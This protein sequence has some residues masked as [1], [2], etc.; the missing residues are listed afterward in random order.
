MRSLLALMAGSALVAAGVTLPLTRGTA[1]DTKRVT[2]HCSSGPNAAF[3]TPTTIRLS[4]GDSLEWRMAGNVASDSIQITLK[5]SD[6]AW[7]FEGTPSRGGA[8]AR[9][10]RALTAGTYSYNVRLLCR[11]PGGGTREEIID[12]DIIIGV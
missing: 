12:P 11:V 7:P 6:Q 10:N 1:A 2:V 9:A 3:V 8:N 5:D 4:L